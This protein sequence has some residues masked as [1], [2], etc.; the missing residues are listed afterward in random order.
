M[1]G[2]MK[3]NLSLLLINN[4]IFF[5]S[6]FALRVNSETTIIAKNGDNL[7]KIS[8]QYGVP[9][10]ELMY[11]NNFNDATKIIEG[12]V[13]IIPL[14]NNAKDTKDNQLIYKV[15]EG[16]TLYTIA[17]NYNINIKDILSINDLYDAS[18]LKPG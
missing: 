5:L 14:K 11:K 18:Y 15:I 2:K 9:L 4:I 3:S 13:V 7:I 17:R 10:K 1:L 12:E 6:L 8:R 16:D